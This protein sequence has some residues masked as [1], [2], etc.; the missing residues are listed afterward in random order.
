VVPTFDTQAWVWIKDQFGNIMDYGM[1]WNRHGRFSALLKVFQ[2]SELIIELNLNETPTPSLGRHFSPDEYDSLTYQLDLDLGDFGSWDL[3]GELVSNETSFDYETLSTEHFDIKY[4]SGTELRANLI[5][6]QMGQAYKVQTYLLADE[7]QRRLLFNLEITMAGMTRVDTMWMG[8][9]S[10]WTWCAPS[11]T[12]STNFVAFHELGHLLQPKSIQPGKFDENFASLLST[13]AIREIFGSRVGLYNKGMHNIDFF[14][15]LDELREK[16]EPQFIL[17]YLTKVHGFDLHNDFFRLWDESDANS[18]RSKLKRQGFT[19]DESIAIIYS[20]L[21]SENLGWLYQLS[22][23][24]MPETRVDLGLDLI[25]DTSAPTISILS[26]EN[27]T[28]L[29]NDV[30]LTL[31]VS[32]LASWMGYSVDGH[33]NVTTLGNTTLSGLLDGTYTL[34]VYA[35]DTAGNMGASSTVY[36]TVDTVAPNIGVL[37]PENKTYSVDSVPVTFTVDESPSW[38]G[39]SVDGHANVTT[40]GN[41]TLSELLD[42]THSLVVY[43]NDTAGNTGASETISFS[44][45]PPP[46]ESFNPLWIMI[47]IV[48]IGGAVTASLI[49]FTKIQKSNRENQMI[50]S[51]AP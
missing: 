32:E 20:F 38:I 19:V 48:I 2:D 4:F 50:M 9:M 39:Y 7:H 44:I 21:V 47:A 29:A 26:P 34:V 14:A 27:M 33:A 43:A 5:A 42:G 24:N 11:Y 18:P 10:Q 30:L 35:N 36:F 6:S 13:E 15:Y 3:S 40:L 41:T 25:A 16:S 49:Y 37:S 46:L 45:E 17:N 28:Y 51:S 31:T 12:S 8:I 1:S 23:I 22:G